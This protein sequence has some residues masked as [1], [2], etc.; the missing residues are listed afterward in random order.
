MNEL[1]LAEQYLIARYFEQCAEFPRTA[2]IPLY[3][4]IIRN[5]KTVIQNWR[6]LARDYH[7]YKWE[8]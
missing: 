5:R 4:Y 1:H 8:S 3:V 6:N 7:L 2:E